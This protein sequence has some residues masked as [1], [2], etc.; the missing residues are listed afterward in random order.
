MDRLY[1]EH[2]DGMRDLFQ[3]KPSRRQSWDPV[4]DRERARKIRFLQLPVIDYDGTDLSMD[5]RNEPHDAMED[6]I[7]IEAATN[8]LR[9]AISR[10]ERTLHYA[11]QHKND[12]GDPSAS[13]GRIKAQGQNAHAVCERH[14]NDTI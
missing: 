6:Q 13:E 5:G 4:K 9:N 10:A 8:T 2:S 7:W 12:G 3:Q 14:I 1:A 11:Q